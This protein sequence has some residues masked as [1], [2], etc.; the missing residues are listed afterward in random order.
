MIL[1]LIDQAP[2]YGV[3]FLL[4]GL[5]RLE[6]VVEFPRK[7]TVHYTTSDGPPLFDCYCECPTRIMTE[8][9]VTDNLRDRSFEF[10]ILSS[11]RRDVANFCS[12]Y[13]ELLAHNDDVL[14]QYDAED[15][16]NLYR[17]YRVPWERYFKREVP[18][19]MQKLVN[20]LPFCYPLERLIDPYLV[21]GRVP[22]LA[23]MV[24]FWDERVG[25][26]RSEINNKIAV[27]GLLDDTTFLSGNRFMHRASIPAYHDLMR[28]CTIALVPPGRGYFTNRHFECIADG[29][30]PIYSTPTCVW[31]NLPPATFCNTADDMVV[32]AKRLLNDTTNEVL[33]NW[34]RCRDWFVNNAT[35]VAR[36]AHMIGV[37]RQKS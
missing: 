33:Y 6:D 22:K 1:Y 36:A 4:H 31:D 18:L 20:S 7:S 32:E 3:D 11:P 15:D 5:S 27:D 28:R 21:N 2:D 16:M 34:L 17:Y 30:L 35:T 26:M 37:L 24:E 25:K 23:F 19:S 12:T 14:A 29:C 13:P 8:E 9:E 10:V